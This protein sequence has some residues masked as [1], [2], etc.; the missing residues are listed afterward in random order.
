MLSFAS[1]SNLSHPG[2]F[3][4]LH[5]GH[6]VKSVQHNSVKKAQATIP[7]KNNSYDALV[8]ISLLEDMGEEIKI[9]L[10]YKLDNENIDE[11]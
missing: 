3:Q 6:F 4:S 8:N 2:G 7:F 11:N 10:A 5:S 1:L 9:G